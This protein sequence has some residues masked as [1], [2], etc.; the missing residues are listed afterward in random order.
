M[1]VLLSNQIGVHHAIFLKA[2]DPPHCGS[3]TMAETRAESPSE[4]A[5][6]H[7][8]YRVLPSYVTP[9]SVQA[10]RCDFLARIQVRCAKG[11]SADCCCC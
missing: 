1:H 7:P 10:E 5:F 9:E 8:Y 3:A 6:V 2:H 11:A 4:L